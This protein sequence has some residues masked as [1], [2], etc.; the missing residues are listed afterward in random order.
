MK[1]PSPRG[2]SDKENGHDG[3]ANEC[4]TN[5]VTFQ[6]M[7]YEVIKVIIEHTNPGDRYNLLFTCKVSPVNDRVFRLMLLI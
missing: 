3:I 2:P 1:I 7:P 6:D 5:P 4:K